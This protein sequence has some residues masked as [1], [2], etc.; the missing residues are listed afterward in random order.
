MKPGT[1]TA[2]VLAGGR[3]SRM[4]GADKGLVELCG[5]PLV[6]WVIDA[7]SPQVDEIVISANRHLD[8]YLGTS[9]RVVEDQL[10]DYQGPLAGVLACGRA[11]NTDFLVVAAVDAPLLPPA[12]VDTLLAELFSSGQSLAVVE[13]AGEIQPTH[14]LFR[15]DL[16]DDLESWLGEGNR[17]MRDWVQRQQ[18]AVVRFDGDSNW[19]VNVNDAQQLSA[20]ADQLC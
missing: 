3:G 13:R 17:K 14:M 16:L 6:R 9:C 12:Y 11:V 7:L 19:F 18:P 10:D 1:V 2:I 4:G 20:L 15:S 5:Q 8:T